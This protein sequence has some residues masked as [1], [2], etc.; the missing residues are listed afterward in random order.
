MSAFPIPSFHGCTSM[1]CLCHFSNVCFS[2]QD[3][4]LVF[5]VPELQNQSTTSNSRLPKT[6]AMYEEKWYLPNINFS[7]GISLPKKPMLIPTKIYKSLT[8]VYFAKQMLVMN[9]WQRKHDTNPSHMLMGMSNMFVYEK[10]DVSSFQSP[11]N[12]PAFDLLLA[13]QCSTING[14]PWGEYVYDM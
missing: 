5:D 9:C 13:H 14:W 10:L 2:P 6:D 8:S 12:G 7:N 1:K 3:G 11:S 4:I